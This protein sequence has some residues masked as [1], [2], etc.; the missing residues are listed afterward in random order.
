MR[1]ENR[2]TGAMEISDYKLVTVVDVIRTAPQEVVLQDLRRYAYGTFS[3]FAQRFDKIPEDARRYVKKMGKLGEKFEF[4]G[5][6]Y[7]P[8]KTSYG[9]QIL[10]ISPTQTVY[11]CS[12]DITKKFEEFVKSPEVEAYL[13]RLENLREQT[14]RLRE[15][16]FGRKGIEF[17]VADNLVLNVHLE[18]GRWIL[19]EQNIFRSDVEANISSNGAKYTKRDLAIA[20]VR[21][22]GIEEIARV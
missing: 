4:N 1:G 8:Y 19:F 5:T 6:L 10:G 3:G 11:R 9:F 7:T 18:F 20:D 22:K 15:I 21:V 13:Q 16:E 14:V 12:R 2:E 17:K